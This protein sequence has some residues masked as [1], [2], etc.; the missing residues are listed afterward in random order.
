[1]FGGNFSFLLSLHIYIFVRNV[2]KYYYHVENKNGKSFENISDFQ[3]VLWFL[4]IKLFFNFHKRYVR[5][6]LNDRADCLVQIFF[7]R[8]L[9]SYRCAVY[10]LKGVDLKYVHR[11]CFLN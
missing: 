2:F 7:Y 8:G 10:L 5:I 4:K 11:N 9:L 1:M 3:A 6:R